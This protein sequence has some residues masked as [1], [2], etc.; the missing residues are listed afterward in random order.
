[1]KRTIKTL[2]ATGVVEV[3]DTQ[4]PYQVIGLTKSGEDRI[5]ADY[6]AR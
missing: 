3:G 4:Q 1:M 2:T 5:L 6:P